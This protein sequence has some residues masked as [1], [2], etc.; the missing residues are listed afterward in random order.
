MKFTDK[1]TDKFAVVSFKRPFLIL[2]F[3]L[4]ITIFMF[5]QSQNVKTVSTDNRDALPD[6]YP[7]LEAFTKM[8]NKFGSSSSAMIVVTFD[9]EDPY[10]VN[11]IREPEILE[12]IYTLSELSS[13]VDDVDEVSSGAYY[14][15]D[16]NGGV[17]P[18]KKS[19]VIELM[20]SSQS[21]DSYFNKR[22]DMALIKISLS[23]AYV[24]EDIYTDLTSVIEQVS[25]P[26]GVKA[27]LGGSSIEDAV[28]T[29]VIGG[30]MGKTSIF[31]MLGIMVVLLLIFRSIKYGVIPLFT[32]GIGVVW[33][34]GYIGLVG[35]TM[36][37]ATSGVL[38]M[39]MGI[40]I[41]FGIQMVS[42]FR[43]ELRENDVQTSLKIMLRAVFVPMTTTTLAAIIGFQA[44][45]LG[46]LTFLAD[47]GTMMMYGVVGCYFVAILAVPSL[48][49]IFETVLRGRST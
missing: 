3:V 31:S 38:S 11:D 16:M 14:L 5:V 13:L 4:I 6:D 2:L 44:M 18:N 19:V 24:E 34:M 41:D 37:S 36:S 8:E 49:V 47:M 25:P 22:H 1:F 9:S 29:Q 10:G 35:M 27:S 17:L 43:Q 15:K 46:E 12:Y 20:D 33:T 28:V 30:D 26:S 39:I 32:I 45:R 7:V 40:G 21:L 48:L 42:R 23:D